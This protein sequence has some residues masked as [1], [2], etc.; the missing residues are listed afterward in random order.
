MA[1]DKCL[2]QKRSEQARGQDRDEWGR[3]CK[4]R[5]GSTSNYGSST[6][7]TSTKDTSTDGRYNRDKS[8]DSRSSDGEYTGRFEIDSMSSE[9]HDRGVQECESSR[10]AKKMEGM[11]KATV[12]KQK[13]GGAVGMSKSY[14]ID[15]I[16]SDEE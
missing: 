9:D 3:F 1:I 8:I 16:S 11:D 6:D 7:A 10:K 15:L 13:N 14:Y 4:V 12:K 2:S 5:R